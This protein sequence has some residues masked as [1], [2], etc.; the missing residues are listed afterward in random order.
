MQASSVDESTLS[1]FATTLLFWILPKLKGL[2]EKNESIFAQYHR[3]T[4][5][6]GTFQR[7]DGCIPRWRIMSY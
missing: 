4:L 7:F 1:L 3:L 6:V 2:V 5:D